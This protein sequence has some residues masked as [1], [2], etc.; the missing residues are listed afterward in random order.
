MT[1]NDMTPDQVREAAIE[2]CRA[3]G[4]DP[5]GRV[6]FGGR[7]VPGLEVEQWEHRA[8]VVRSWLDIM[9]AVNKVAR[10]YDPDNDQGDTRA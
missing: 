3:Q 6:P 4:I 5:F 10:R 7:V 1:L 2:L 9:R 8:A